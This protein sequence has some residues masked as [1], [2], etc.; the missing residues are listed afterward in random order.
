VKTG[1]KFDA[2][3]QPSQVLRHGTTLMN[4]VHLRQKQMSAGIINDGT[5]RKE[6]HIHPKEK[7]SPGLHNN[8]L[9]LL[10][11]SLSRPPSEA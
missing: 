11:L 6:A 7:V 10:F 5:L 9:P 2:F 3:N 1:K 4:Q 8:T